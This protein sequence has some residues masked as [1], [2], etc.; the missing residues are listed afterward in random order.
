MKTVKHIIGLFILALI[1]MSFSQCS[2]VPKIEDKV[3][4]ALEEVFYMKW[5]AGVR[6]GG[7]GLNITV[8][9]K[10]NNL[11]LDSVYFRGK[12][13]KLILITGKEHTFIGRFLN[14]DHKKSSIILDEDPKNEFGN[15]LP[16]IAPK[17][18]FDLKED[19]CVISYK[20]GSKI[21]YFMMK[22]VHEKSSMEQP[23]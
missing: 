5:S 22:G 6:G 1:L 4:G 21:K 11:E 16:V 3:P 7:S 19:E 2:N 15:T 12:S 17:S 8:K 14:E 10:D 23:M 9:L 20:A 18:Q 13:A